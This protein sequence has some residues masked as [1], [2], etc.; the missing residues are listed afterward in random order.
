[1]FDNLFALLFGVR[2]DPEPADVRLARVLLKEVG[3]PDDD[4]IDRHARELVD[5]L[6]DRRRESSRGHDT[7]YDTDLIHTEGKFDD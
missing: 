1:M 6:R 4:D 5:E 3:F 7:D 2:V